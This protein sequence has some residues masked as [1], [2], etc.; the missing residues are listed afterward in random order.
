MPSP[1]PGMNPFLELPSLCPS[2]H[3]RL[4]V[5]IA[6]GLNPQLRPHY[7]VEIEERIY[8]DGEE[9]LLVGIP[10]NVITQS[11]T[12]TQPR[13]EFSAAVGT[14]EPVTIHLVEVD[15]LRC[16]QPLPMNSTL[17]SAYRIL[18]SRSEQRPQAT[19]YAFGLRDRIPTVAIPLATELDT[20]EPSIDLQALLHQTYD[21]GS[22]DLAIDY[23]SQLIPKF[24]QEDETW[25]TMQ[26]LL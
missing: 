5:A 21:R 1:F 14:I 25:A 20:P 15:L 11:N 18:I 8:Q 9:R 4:I 13:T 23:Q 22:H 2:V 12:T 16:A 10:D 7:R 19:L 17:S 6:D 24:T 26:L 3:K